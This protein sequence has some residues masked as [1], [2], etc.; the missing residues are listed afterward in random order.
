MELAVDIAADDD[1]SPDWLNVRL[2]KE[3]LLG[4]LAELLDF[5]LWQWFAVEKLGDLLVQVSV[6][7]PTFHLIFKL[8]CKFC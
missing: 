5:G 1:G 8:S 4:F 3:N 2:L 6:I 7:K